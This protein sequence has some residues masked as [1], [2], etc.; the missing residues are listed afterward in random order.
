[1]AHGFVRVRCDACGQDQLVAFS[2]KQRGI[3]PS[4][5]GKRMTEG[6]AHLVES[7]LP[8]VPFRQ[9][10]LTVP[11]DLRYVLAWNRELRTAVLNAFIR[12]VESHYRREARLDGYSGGHC[13]AVSVLQRFDGSLRLSPH[14]H[15]LFADG[16]WIEQGKTDPYFV[17]AVP[18]REGD[19]AKVLADAERRIWRQ[20]ER[21]GWTDRNNDPLHERDPALSA[22]L[23][24]SL[25]NRAAAGGAVGSA[26]VKQRGPK[27]DPAN[28]KPNGRN[29]ATLDGFSLHANTRVGPKARK[30]LEELC[31]YLLRPGV[32]AK[33]IA[34]TDD[35]KVRITLKSSWKDGTTAVELKP[36]DFMVRLAALV[37]LPRHAIQRYHGVFAPNA[38]LRGAIV[39]AGPAPPTSRRRA[40]AKAKAA[41]E[42]LE[43][44]DV[45]PAAIAHAAE[46]ASSR[47][48]WSQAWQRAFGGDLLECSC[49]GRKRVIAVIHAGPVAT[50]ILQ[51]V[52]L[53][54][55]ADDFVAIRG[56]PH[57]LWPE[58]DDPSEA[59]NEDGIDLPMWTDCDEGPAVDAVA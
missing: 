53:P 25:W 1:L 50:R 26:V 2:C 44:V 8:G 5:D 49:G 31:R 17:Q 3:C 13:G 7:V 46:R 56:P 20:V 22:C 16:V 45:S 19:V 51:H 54:T 55:T 39:P 10:V 48:T 6:A 18:P 36:H 32:P 34:Q 57:L 35:G 4:C 38:K 12:A 33:R 27:P 41:A 14:W 15:V 43:A 58:E 9:W 40:M 59:A 28:A 30:Q 52:G 29:C 42:S 23:Q 47:L 37:P 11:F 24:A 21:L